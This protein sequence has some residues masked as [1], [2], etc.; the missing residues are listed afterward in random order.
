M[1]INNLLIFSTAYNIIAGKFGG[2]FKL[3]SLRINQP[4]AKY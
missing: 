1:N 4:T 2:E 3:G